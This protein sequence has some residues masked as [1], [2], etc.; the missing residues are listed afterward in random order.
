VGEVFLDLPTRENK[1]ADPRGAA[2][3]R[4][5]TGPVG[6]M[7]WWVTHSEPGWHCSNGC[8]ACGSKGAG[9]LTSGP[10]PF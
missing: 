2:S 7:Q 3:G 9:W 5:R 10:S 1:L 4:L 6:M 8:R